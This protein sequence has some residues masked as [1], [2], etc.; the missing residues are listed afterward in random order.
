[1]KHGQRPGKPAIKRTRKTR[2][3]LASRSGAIDLA[4]VTVG[5]AVI[6]IMA[7]STFAIVGGVVPW[8]QDRTARHDLSAITVAQ[9]SAE[10]KTNKYLT[11]ADLADKGLL[12]KKNG[13]VVKVFDIKDASG[14]KTGECYV[15]ISVS[16]SGETY[17]VTNNKTE[18]QKLAEDASGVG[19][20]SAALVKKMI[21]EVNYNTGASVLSAPAAPEVAVAYAGGSKVN[22]TWAI[23]GEAT[24]ARRADHYSLEYRIGTG[25]WTVL[26]NRLVDVKAAVPGEYGKRTSVRMRAGN[27]AGLS[28]YSTERGVTLPALPAKPVIGGAAASG[29]ASASFAWDAVP[30][31]DGYGVEYS[32]N[33]GAWL[34]RSTDQVSTALSVDGLVKGDRVKA[35]VRSLN[36][37]GASA[38]TESA[39]VTVTGA[40]GTPVVSGTRTGAGTAEFMWENTGASDYRVESRVNSGAWTVVAEKQTAVEVTIPAAAGQKIGVR[41]RAAGSTVYSAVSTVVMPSTPPA[42]ADIAGSLSDSTTAV[43]TWP[44][45]SG[46]T[47]YIV[48]RYTGTGWE[49]APEQTATTTSISTTKAVAGKITVRIKSVGDAGI[50]GVSASVSVSEPSAPAAPVLTASLRDNATA[51]FVWADVKGAA[52]YQAQSRTAGGAWTDIDLDSE[53]LS[54]TVAGDPGQK[55]EVRVLAVNSIGASPYSAVSVK[56]L[57]DVPGS[58]IFTAKA[59]SGTELSVSWPAIPGAVS[60][61]VSSSIAGDRWTDTEVSDVYDVIDTGEVAGQAVEVKVYAVNAVGRSAEPTALKVTLPVIAN[62]PSPKAAGVTGTGVKLTWGA[63]PGAVSYRVET[64]NGESWLPLEPKVSGTSVIIPAKPGETISARVRS[65]NLAGISKASSPVSATMMALPDAPA[66]KGELTAAVSTRFIWERVGTADLGYNI[67][68]SVNGGAWISVASGTANTSLVLTGKAGQSIAVRSQSINAAGVSEWSESVSVRLP[69]IPGVPVVTGEQSSDSTATFFW[70]TPA[71][72]ESYRVEYRIDGGDWE[73]QSANQADNETT[74]MAEAGMTV[75]VRVQSRNLAGASAYSTSAVTLD[76]LALAERITEVTAVVKADGVLVAWDE[77]AGAT[78][79]R[80]RYTLDGSTPTSTNGTQV[81]QASLNYKVAA[82]AGSTLK[83]RVQSGNDQDVWSTSYTLTL[84]I[85]AR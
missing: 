81:I 62:V 13:S 6:G 24:A 65:E 76:D 46:A 29:P 15:G 55:I 5:A 79:Y 10:L 56:T 74:I 52:S 20:G 34:T 9:S 69:A 51:S 53:A 31:A 83:F 66:V 68:K 70:P 33:Y 30:A 38:Y 61:T 41:V 54:L 17:F 22:L 32:V 39:E 77:P 18:P 11:T 80:I 8:S 2:R 71:E 48:E 21:T 47:G 12:D 16:G 72:A 44:A 50:S 36:L 42:P 1:M 58:P 37:A 57:P 84:E 23:A 67:E 27:A 26:D 75:G 7:A 43:F 59:V 49:I 3:P 60:Y 45:V 25:P 82:A 35:R 19:C 78:Q 85:P 63:V 40:V 4:S 14:T 64:S 28:A 73:L